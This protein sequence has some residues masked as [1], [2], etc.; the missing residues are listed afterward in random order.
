M[1]TSFLKLKKIAIFFYIFFIVIDGLSQQKTVA[2][3]LEVLSDL[4]TITNNVASIQANIDQAF[5]SVIENSAYKTLVDGKSLSFPYAIV[6]DGD[7]RDYA[8]VVNAVNTDNVGRRTAEIFMKIPVSANE[9][10]YFLADKVPLNKSG[11]LTD[12]LKLFLLKTASQKVGNG[13]ELIFKGLDNPNKEISY[14]SFSCS[15][16][17][18][19]FLNGQ[20]KFDPNTVVLHSEDENK[21]KQPVNLDFFVQADYLSNFIVSFNSIPDLNFTSLPGFK[22][23]IP[24]LTLDKSDQD[25]DT[26]F[27][28]PSWYEASLK[29][30]FGSLSAV[31]GGPIWE[32]IYIPEITIEIPKAFTEGGDHAKRIIAANDFIVDE[33]GISALTKVNSSDDKGILSGNIQGF[34]HQLNEV[35]INV[36]F[37]SLSKAGFKGQVSIPIC[38]DESKIDFGLTVSRSTINDNQLEYKGFASSKTNLNAKMFGIAQLKINTAELEFEYKQKQFYPAVTLEGSL[39]IVP[40]KKGASSGSGNL[41][42]EFSKLHVGSKKAYV[43]ILPDG[44]FRLKSGINNSKLGALPVS[45]TTDPR[46]V[47]DAS[48]QRTGLEMGISVSF[49]ES[50]SDS[51]ESASGFSAGGKFVLWADRHPVTKRWAYDDFQLDSLG[52]KMTGSGF[53][54]EGYVNIW[55]EED[56]IYGKGFCG[57]LELEVIEKFTVKA[58]AIFGKKDVVEVLPDATAAAGA[59]FQFNDNVEPT[60]STSIYRYWFVDAAVSFSPG[61]PLFAGIEMNTFTGG[62]YKNMNMMKEPSKSEVQCL[63][64]SGR[65]YEPKQGLM[66]LIAGIGIQSTGEVPLIMET[67]T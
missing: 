45:F 15:G 39:S 52:I 24:S 1:F 43:S 17:N 60:N 66:G 41:S 6:K 56:P 37:S 59:D 35:E 22:V 11:N 65:F 36:L 49:Q 67:S 55:H 42:L 50:N 5:N 9:H 30:K 58:T 44:Y 47:T 27:S 20:L 32:G 33:N 13:Y 31:Y 18:E 38:D 46:L 54:L 51:E 53:N 16:F 34:K 23:K 29:E 25:N 40:K 28:F 7:S 64:A 48:G 2:T 12:T 21:P 62:V 14:V 10:L 4:K 61:I 19:V 63:T 3:G 8:L 26:N 57:Q